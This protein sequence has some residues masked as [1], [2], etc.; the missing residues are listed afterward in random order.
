MRSKLAK[1][2]PDEAR[3]LEKE[4]DELAQRSKSIVKFFAPVLTSSNVTPEAARDALAA[5][6]EKL[7]TCLPPRRTRGS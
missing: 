1:A 2:K 5:N 4:C 6:G 7:L 3:K